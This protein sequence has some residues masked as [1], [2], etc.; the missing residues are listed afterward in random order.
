VWVLGA[1]YVGT[2]ILSIYLAA[3]LHRRHT[4]MFVHWVS[5]YRWAPDY[6]ARRRG[7]LRE[8]SVALVAD[9]SN[10]AK[11]VG[12]GNGQRASGS[13]EALVSC[14]RQG[15]FAYRRSYSF[16]HDPCSTA[17]GSVNMYRN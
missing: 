6:K 15:P 14:T 8:Q 7:T 16:W 4:I 11:D 9:A 1:C 13:G 2:G 5:R 12:T 3:L 10:P 17:S